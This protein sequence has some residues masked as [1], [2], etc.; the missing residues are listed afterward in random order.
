MRHIGKWCV[1]SAFLWPMQA[2]ASV[3]SPPEC[4]NPIGE[5]VV[6]ATRDTVRSGVAAGMAN[7]SAD[8][9]PMVFRMNYESA[10]PAFQRFIDLHECAHHQTGDVDRPHPPRNSPAHLM[11]ESIAD[12]VAILRIRDESADPE[13]VM[14]ELI[15]ALRSAMTQVG[16]PEISTTS[17]VA[18]LQH[19]YANYGSASE[20]ISGVRASRN[21]D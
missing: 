4:T 2:L 5:T 9:T 6:F 8:G 10:P 20:F 21:P 12:C 19:C 15:P 11:N 18:N 1:L 17:R 13:A 3:V 7:R 14:A 16:F